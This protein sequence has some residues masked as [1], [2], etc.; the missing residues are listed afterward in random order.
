MQKLISSLGL[1]VT[2]IARPSSAGAG[3][4]PVMS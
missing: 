4:A 3:N 1:P 2:L